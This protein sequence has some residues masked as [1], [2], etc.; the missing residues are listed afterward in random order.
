MGYVHAAF[1]ETLDRKVAIKLIRDEH[2]HSPHARERLLRE[3]AAL[4]ERWPD[5]ARRPPL[6]GVPVGLKDI[7]AAD[8][9]AT[10][11]GS[12]VPAESFAM[13]EGAVVRR[14]REAG[15]LIAGKTVT[16]E[17]AFFDPG[18]TAN[19]HA[20]GHTPGGSSSGSAAAVAAGSVALAL[21]SQTVGSVIRPAAFC[22]IVG[23]KP[24]Y[25]RVPIDG[26]LPYSRSVDTL[27]WFTQ[28]V[29]GARLAAAVLVDGW[30]ESAAAA[31]TAR[32][33][34]GVPL[35]AYLD[36]AEPAARAAFDEQLTQ[37]EGAGYGV[38]RVEAL[39][40]IAGIAARHRALT[41]AEFAEVHRDR[42]RDYAAL[43]RPRSAMLLDLAAAIPEQARVA[44]LAGRAA[45][46]EALYALMAAHG[47]DAWVSPAATGPAPEGLGSTGD[48]SMNLPWTHAGLPVV[49]V[50]AGRTRDGRPLGLQIA[51]RFGADEA[52][53]AW[54]TPIAALF[55]RTG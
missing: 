30:D 51:G 15:A 11:A 4:R 25:G 42:F 54:A 23:V 9:F 26:V 52:L 55:R 44:G 29:E 35:G 7:I 5:P 16:T 22:G 12:A 50:P 47:I 2:A 28:D 17:F 20:T 27:G 43:F 13:A 24:S 32:P 37:L 31:V 49:T 18:P 38:R 41:T 45:L 33:V 3:A 14:L 1:D 10:R 36:Q 53:L 6:Y 19:P 48:P 46:R 21:G 39:G 40:D 8:G 34:L